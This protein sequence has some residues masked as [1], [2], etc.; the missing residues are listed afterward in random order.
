MPMS[1]PS[2][3][4]DPFASYDKLREEAP[5][6]RMCYPDGTP[7]WVVTS[8]ADVHKG[9]WDPMLVRPVEAAGPDFAMRRFPEGAKTGTLATLD[10]PDHTRLR[11]FVN[12]AFVP[13]RVETMRPKVE[14][15]VD[16]LLDAI[17]RRGEADLVADLASPLP[18]AVV[19]DVLGV[20]EALRSKVH[21]WSNKAFDGDDDTNIE[22]NKIMIGAFRKLVDVKR[23]EPGDD[24]ITYWTTA[25]DD[26]GVALTDWE[27]CAMAVFVVTAGYET[28][29]SMITQCAKFLLE[30]PDVAATLRAAPERVPEALEEMMRATTSVHHSFRR[31]AKEDMVIAGQQVAKGDCVLLHV[32]AAH[33][34]SAHFP[35]GTEFDLDRPDK[36]HLTFG[37]GV[38]YCPGAE[39]ARLELVAALRGL[40][41]RFPAMKLAV[42]VE[43]LTRRHNPW[44]PAIRGLPVVV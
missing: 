41:T 28:T 2:F 27:I 40:V 34:D 5:I 6:H 23:A 3:Y 35:H 22:T 38:H 33:R 9:M 36:K 21:E 4:D 7:V 15:V 31:F 42:P 14:A 10:P 44:I 37:R 39:L 25:T 19:G 26:A 12:W 13:K 1:D 18:L 17:E 16:G 29:S 24:L 11:K 32:A 8:F 30:R 43:E 20:P